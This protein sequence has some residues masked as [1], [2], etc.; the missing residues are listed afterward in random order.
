MNKTIIIIIIIIIIT[1]Q[2]INIWELEI[3]NVQKCR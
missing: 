1:M 2:T 3:E